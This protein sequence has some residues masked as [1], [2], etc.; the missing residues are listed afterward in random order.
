MY[1]SSALLMYS[2]RRT[3]STAKRH[4]KICSHLMSPSE[5][6]PVDYACLSLPA[7]EGGVTEERHTPATRVLSEL[8]PAAVPGGPATD[9]LATVPDDA[10][11]PTGSISMETAAEPE[12][13]AP[14]RRA[15]RAEA[16][17]VAGDSLKTPFVEEEPVAAQEVVKSVEVEEPAA[18]ETAMND[19]PAVSTVDAALAVDEDKVQVGS[20]P[21]T[22]CAGIVWE[23]ELA[24]IG[25]RLRQYIAGVL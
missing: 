16:T 25:E 14:M 17:A 20:N 8:R 10:T 21:E 5:R 24:R 15:P 11:G 12:E 18:V 4:L 6:S 9:S 2:R 19:V 7:A 22:E 3:D 23:S 1:Y 13:G